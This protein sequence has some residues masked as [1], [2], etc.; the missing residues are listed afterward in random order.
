MSTTQPRKLEEPEKEKRRREEG[1]KKVAVTMSGLS[2]RVIVKT[3]NGKS[4]QFRLLYIH[5]EG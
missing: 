5:L 2:I 1:R 4:G 3:G